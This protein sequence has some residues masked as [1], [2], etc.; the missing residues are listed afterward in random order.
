MYADTRRQEPHTKD[1]QTCAEDSQ[2]SAIP[3]LDC[4]G[5]KQYLTP[6]MELIYRRLAPAS[7]LPTGGDVHVHRRLD[8]SP[9][10]GQTAVLIMV[11]I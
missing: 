10:Y 6:C 9:R 5:R 2:S 1:S 11:V 8:S 4:S 7:C 3:S